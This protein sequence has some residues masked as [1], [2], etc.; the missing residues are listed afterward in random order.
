VAW[1]EAHLVSQ[2]G[3]D[4][5]GGVFPGSPVVLHGHNRNLG[6]A[7]TVNMPDLVDIYVLDMNPDN[8]NQYK[9]DGEWRDLEVETIKLDVRIFGP[10]RWK[11]KREVLWSVYGPTVRQPH[12]VYAIR[13]AGMGEIRQVEQ[14]YRMGKAKNFDEWLDV[15][16]T[17]R[18][19]S[20]NIGYADRKG[21]IFYLYNA[22]FPIRA[23]GYRWKDYLPG[24]TSE[25]LWTEFLPFEKLP[26]IKNPA[27]G[28][29][30][31]CNNT[32]FQT[33][34][35]P[36]NPNPED[37]SPTLGID[38]M[39]TN[40]A[41]R[42]LELFGG[43][44][45]I[46][47][48]EFYQYK[49]DTAYSKDSLAKECLEKIFAAPAPD[50]PVVQE[51]IEVLHQWDYNTD[52]ENPAAAI[53]ILTL[54][55]LVRAQLFGNDPP[56]AMEILSKRAH[57]LKETYGRIDVPWGEVNRIVRGDADMALSGGPDVLHAIYGKLKEGRLIGNAGDSYILMASWDKDGNVSSRSIHQFG[58]ATLDEDSP[59]YADQVP[60][61]A[62]CETKPVWFD[63]A[64]IRKHIE[65]EYRPGEEIKPT[66]ELSGESTPSAAQDS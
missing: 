31:N 55:P 56:D 49:F 59:H 28:F 5:V 33:T 41:L 34:V 51:A 30:Q 23:E 15:V 11:V 26:Q 27:S 10:L 62:K 45:S 19:P 48:E 50:D 61:F 35:G 9:F 2:E 65:S 63:E 20:F 37:Y 8:P 24:N 36:E 16:R 46:T 66:D 21:N 14:W 29:I 25:T 1:Y 22:L 12:G 54:E 42:A 39:M 6:W 7:H 40:R 58:S 32:P 43:D 13:Y 60:L 18:I 17:R 53:A 44:D 4:I 52:V 38:T 57:L 47:K 3:M 64:E